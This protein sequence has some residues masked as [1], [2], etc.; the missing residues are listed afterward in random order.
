MLRQFENAL[1]TPGLGGPKS[2]HTPGRWTVLPTFM[3]PSDD[4]NPK[5]TT[6]WWDDRKSD[7][8]PEDGQ[9][10]HGNYAACAGSTIFN[11]RD[12][13]NL[14]DR[15]GKNLNGMFYALS[16]TN[17]AQVEDGTSNTLMVGDLPKRRCKTT[18]LSLI[19]IY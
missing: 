1:A 5:N 15:Q 18:L 14:E 2:W 17:F 11:P 9:G 10:F 19:R 12:T 16:E 7:G 6:L 3:C 13:G 8:T 4:A